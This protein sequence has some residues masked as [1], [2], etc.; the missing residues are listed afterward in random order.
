MPRTDSDPVG[1][2]NREMGK[3]AWLSDVHLNFLAQKEI[4]RFLAGVAAGRPAAVLVGGDISEAHRIESDLLLMERNLKVPIYFVLGNHDYYRGAIAGVR[5]KVAAL[6]RGSALLRYLTVEGVVELSPSTAL[7]GH[8]GWGDA[9]LGAWNTSSVQLSDFGL[10][11]ELKYLLPE[12]RIAV[13]RALGDEAAAHL[14]KVLPPALEK[15]QHI[16]ILTHVPPWREACWYQGH[17]SDDEYLPYFACQ[18]TGEVLSRLARAYP[19]RELLCLCGHTHSPGQAQILPNLRVLTAASD[20]HH[21][22]I[23][24]WLEI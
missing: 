6:C 11:E 4:D 15:Y 18:A 19:Q 8:D 3:A 21:P 7:V 10:I 16:I 13:L 20:Y 5:T 1:G 23:G 12:D 17:L 22:Q 2:Y 14:A 24:Q 9:R